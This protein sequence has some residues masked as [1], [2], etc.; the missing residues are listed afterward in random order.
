MKVLISAE[1]ARDVG[2]LI[3]PH[4]GNP[5]DEGFFQPLIRRTLGTGVEFIGYPSLSLGPEPPKAL[6]KKLAQRAWRAVTLA[7]AEDCDLAVIHTDTDE[8]ASK[9][10][11]PTKWT[12]RRELL[13][14]GVDQA[15]PGAPPVA[16]AVPVATTEAWALAD[17]AVIRDRAVTKD[18]AL[19]KSPELLWGAPHDSASNHPKCLLQRLLGNSAG[20]AM[21]AE[22]AKVMDLQ[23]ARKRCPRSLEPFLA[24][25]EA[26]R[27]LR[28]RP[29]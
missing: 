3:D 1:G 28:P 27:S 8:A 6:N 14:S 19:K 20:A 16:L 7:D 9:T 5:K 2:G 22:L 23:V 12:A 17:P 18:A 25:V 26:T 29:S 21:Q 15:G 24:E 10:Q 11:A 13:R 4:Y